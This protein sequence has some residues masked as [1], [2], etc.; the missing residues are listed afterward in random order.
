MNLPNL[1]L[2]GA[3]KSG[4]TTLY[5]ILSRYPEVFMSHKKSTGFFSNDKHYSKGLDRYVKTCFKGADQYPIRGEATPSYLTSKE[6]PHRIRKHIPSED[7]RFI[8]IFRNPVDRAYSHYWFN[9]N[10]KI[11]PNEKVSF[12]EALLREEQWVSGN[13]VPGPEH[14]RTQYYFQNGQYCYW[15]KEYLNVFDEKQF[16]F[17]FLMIYALS[18]FVGQQVVW[19]NF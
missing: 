4:T 9:R 2:I 19:R 14:S 10:T 11:R 17:C 8:V 15:L 7:L 5:S 1:F 16:L 3:A 13:L 18:N 6:M 12:E